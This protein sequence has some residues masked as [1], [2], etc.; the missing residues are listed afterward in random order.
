MIR[1]E[2]CFYSECFTFRYNDG[3]EREL[4]ASNT[5]IKRIALMEI[6]TNTPPFSTTGYKSINCQHGEFSS[7]TSIAG[8]IDIGCMSGPFI[9]P[10]KQPAFSNLSDLFSTPSLL[11]EEFDESIFEEIDA[12]C[13]HQS[14]AKAEE[15][16]LNFKVNMEGQQN[17]N[18]I[19]NDHIATL[20]LTTNENVR[21]ESAVDT[22]NCFGLKEE[23]L[24]TLGD[25]QSGNMPDEY[26]KYLQSLNDKQREAAC[27]DIS[28]PLMI[29][30]G[31]GSGKVSYYHEFS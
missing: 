22:R 13:E 18:N 25:K 16:H 5:G 30:A 21:A 4:P 10:K 23:D 19:S 27:S 26:S 8:S 1:N 7:A 31:P 2:S 28:I 17:D 12:I 24:C 20:P 3:I 6:P 15:D 29:V 9:T 14:A 11:E